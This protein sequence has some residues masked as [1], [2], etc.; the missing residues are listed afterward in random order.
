MANSWNMFSRL[1]T[2]TKLYYN[3]I[4]VKLASNTIA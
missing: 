3:I 1:F 2:A 4:N